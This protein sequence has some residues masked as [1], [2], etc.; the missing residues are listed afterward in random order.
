MS[1]DRTQ[2]PSQRRRQMA[3]EQGQVAHSPELTGAVGLLAAVALLSAR[4][5]GIASALLAIVRAPLEGGNPPATP[6]AL[7]ALLRGLAVQVAVPAGGVIGGAALAALAAHQLQVGGIWVPGLIAPDP[8]RLAGGT[9]G[10]GLGA[11]SFGGA[12]AL[13][14]ALIVIAV[15]AGSIRA[16]LPAFAAIGT[17]GP[18]VLAVEV[19]RST[20]GLAGALGGASL[21]LG[22]VDLAVRRQRLEATLRMTP[23]EHRQDERAADGDPGL[24]A[25]RRQQAKAWRDDPGDVLPGATLIL[26]G[27]SGLALVLG[28]GPPPRPITVR[29]VAQGA[30]GTRIR[31]SAEA[32]GIPARESHALA[33]RVAARRG[34]GS[35]LSAA[36]VAE[37]AALWPP[38]HRRPADA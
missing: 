7:V 18:R 33:R 14:R 4:G 9:S 38:D 37:L 29:T 15:A 31:R 28:G 22:L 24:L 26:C 30:S 13:A 5:G 8:S 19:G 16:G 12:W 11:R 17:H 2:D 6:E 3:R 1:E 21:A 10:P 35:P 27:P 23:D 34:D 25:R 32:A 20:L 36:D